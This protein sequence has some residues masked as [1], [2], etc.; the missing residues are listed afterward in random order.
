MEHCHAFITSHHSF[1]FF[2]PELA[3]FA[4]LRTPLTFTVPS[5]HRHDLLNH[6]CRVQGYHPIGPQRRYQHSARGKEVIL[7]RD[8]RTIKVISGPNG[9]PFWPIPFFY[10]SSCMNAIGA[11]HFYCAYPRFTLTARSFLHPRH[12]IDGNLPTVAMIRN[13]YLDDLLGID[14]RTTPLSWD[15]AQA[16]CSH[17]EACPV[18]RRHFLDEF[19]LVMPLTTHD[20]FERPTREGSCLTEWKL[21][22]W[23]RFP[24]DTVFVCFATFVTRHM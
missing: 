23:E 18:R 19:A 24:L 12:M 8:E 1:A 17:A 14:T 7:H 6:L 20:A 2:H 5:E 13:I 16:E 10:S 9:C 4:N 15:E 11:T 3:Y 22:G 21:G